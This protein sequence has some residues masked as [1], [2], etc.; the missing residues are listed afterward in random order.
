MT[1]IIYSA[2]E[3]RDVGRTCLAAINACAA[4]KINVTLVLMPFS[5]KIFVAAS[6]SGTH[7]ILMIT[8]SGNSF[9]SANVFHH[10]PAVSIAVTSAGNRAST[11]CCNLGYYLLEISTAF[12][13]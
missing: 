3:W 4:E 5:V 11:N 7:G 10:G 2:Y 6:P 1:S 8:F 9:F 12:F 13:D